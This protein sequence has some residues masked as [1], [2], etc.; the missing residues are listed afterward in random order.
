MG[1]GEGSTLSIFDVRF[2]RKL[3]SLRSSYNEPIN[4][5][6]FLNNNDKN[7]IFSNKKQI[8]ITNG[9]GQFFTSVEPENGINMCT[10]VKNSGLILAALEDPKIGCFFIPQLGPAPKW[11]PFIENITE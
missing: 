8:K 4:S 10:V 9:E 3:M 2:D 11:V 1:M 5:I 7:I 6:H